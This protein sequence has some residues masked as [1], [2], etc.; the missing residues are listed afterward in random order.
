MSKENLETEMSLS[1]AFPSDE[2]IADVN[3]ETKEEEVVEEEEQVEETEEEVKEVVESKKTT[4]KTKEE[5]KEKSGGSA[6]TAKEVYKRNVELGI[7]DEIEEEDIDWEDPNVLKEIHNVIAS[8]RGKGGEI[9]QYQKNGGDVDE[10]VEL[11]MHERQVE[12]LVRNILSENEEISES[13]K[14]YAIRHKY[15][16]IGWDD[17]KIAKQ[18]K[19]WQ[20]EEGEENPT[21]FDDEA[22]NAVYEMKEGVVAEIEAKKEAAKKAYEQTQKKRLE[23]AEKVK[24]LTEDK[25]EGKKAYK[26]FTNY[27]DNNLNEV[28]RLYIE[29]RNNPELALELFRFLDNP[30]SYKKKVSKKEVKEALVER[31]TKI[32][33]KKKP[34]E[35]EELADAFTFFG[36]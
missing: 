16:S 13:A 36:E 5:V 23:L 8:E 29:V 1:F 31:A 32:V 22:V 28:D 14:L 4:T 24:S 3:V 10:L 20:S 9:Q 33:V 21:M 12:G 27:D 26:A 25:E 2:A 35:K 34:T 19:L 6:P 17:K 30:E 15:K 18:I 7:W 11:M